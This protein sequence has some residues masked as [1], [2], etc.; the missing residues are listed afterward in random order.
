[1]LVPVYMLRE[2]GCATAYRKKAS[3]PLVRES[4]PAA[5]IICGTGKLSC[6]A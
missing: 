2:K 1:M 5:P 3:V 4:R 6:R